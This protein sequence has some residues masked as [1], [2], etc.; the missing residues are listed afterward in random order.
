MDLGSPSKIYQNSSGPGDYELPPLTGINQLDSS[1]INSPSY[2]FG[3]KVIKS[4]IS[5]YHTQVTLLVNLRNYLESI[6]LA[7]QLI[8]PKD[9]IKNIRHL[10]S[11]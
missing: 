10:N 2:S 6:H 5:K 9:M 7:H 4:I 3:T 8:V 1:K 11:Q